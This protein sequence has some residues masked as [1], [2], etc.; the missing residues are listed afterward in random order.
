MNYQVGDLITRRNSNG[1]VEKAVVEKVQTAGSALIDGAQVPASVGSPIVTARMVVVDGQRV[2]KTKAVRQFVAKEEY[3][4]SEDEYYGL[5]ERQKALYS[6]TESIVESFGQFD[7]G[8]DGN[9]AHYM[10]ATDN[11]FV[12]TGM[13]C[14]NC[15][16]YEGGRH[17]EWVSGDIDPQALCKLWVISEP[18]LA[19]QPLPAILTAEELGMAKA[20]RRK[21]MDRVL[22]SADE[23]RFTL[24]PWYIPDKYDAHQEWTD[25]SEL[26][27]ALWDYVDSGDRDI[28]LQHNRDIK[29]GK[30]V[31]AMTLP[32]EWS[33][34]VHKA[35][36]EMGAHVY[37]SGT[38][39]LGVVWE[40]WAW[41]MVK[42]GEITGFSIGGSA[43]RVN[44][45]MPA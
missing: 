36:G 8:H 43:E 42:K 11:P 30:W 10:D 25:A 12:N 22:K 4:E 38:V 5:T 16:A 26:Q 41:D 28:R 20:M 7:K 27:K 21:E 33:V 31:E 6:A 39:L 35:N 18:L 13:K 24:A 44:L 3:S 15:V 17:C 45:E 23:A 9:G 34:P 19:P 32:Y 1:K 40:P 37:P 14:A 2:L 29:A